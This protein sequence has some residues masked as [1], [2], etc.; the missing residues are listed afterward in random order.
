MK[1][2]VNPN[3]RKFQLNILLSLSSQ[4]AE[5][6]YPVDNVLFLTNRSYQESAVL[7]TTEAGKIEFWPVFGVTKPS[8]MILLN[9]V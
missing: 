1:R 4:E 6:V 2:A 7:V 5:P 3:E 8:G 9:F